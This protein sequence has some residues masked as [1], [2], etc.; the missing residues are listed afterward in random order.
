MTQEFPPAPTGRLEHL[1]AAFRGLA[2]VIDPAPDLDSEDRDHVYFLIM[3]LTEHLETCLQDIMKEF[4]TLHTALRQAQ[5]TPPI[6]E[7]PMP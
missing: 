3:L 5:A 1:I 7:E 6:P 2:R 4:A